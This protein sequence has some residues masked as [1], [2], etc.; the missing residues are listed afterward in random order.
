VVAAAGLIWIMTWSKVLKNVKRL[1]VHQSD[2]TVQRAS[3]FI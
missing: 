2:E 3:S 1:S